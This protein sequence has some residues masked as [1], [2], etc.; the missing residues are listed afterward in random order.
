ML[1]FTVH[2]DS[3]FGLLPATILRPNQVMVTS[4]GGATRAQYDA[5]EQRYNAYIVA[6]LKKASIPISYYSKPEDVPVLLREA[7]AHLIAASIVR[8]FDNPQNP[9]KDLFATG[10]ILLRQYIEEYMIENK[11]ILNAPEFSVDENITAADYSFIG[12]I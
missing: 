8:L 4:K 11:S 6:E 9:Y 3:V 5:A 7:Q 10:N 1:Y 12:L 2:E